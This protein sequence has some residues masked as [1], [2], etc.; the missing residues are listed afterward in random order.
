MKLKSLARKK[1]RSLV[2]SYGGLLPNQ[3]RSDS[4]MSGCLLYCFPN[5]LQ[6]ENH[7]T[8]EHSSP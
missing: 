7:F 3:G 5:D 8:K 2:F 6:L 4:C 1:L